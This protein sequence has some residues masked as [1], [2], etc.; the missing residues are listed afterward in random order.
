MKIDEGRNRI[1]CSQICGVQTSYSIIMKFCMP[2]LKTKIF[3]ELFSEIDYS[4]QKQR[5]VDSLCCNSLETPCRIKYSK[6]QEILPTVYPPP[7]AS[8]HLHRAGACCGSSYS[9]LI[10][11]FPGFVLLVLGGAIALCVFAIVGN[12]VN[13]FALSCPSKGEAEEKEERKKDTT[14]KERK[15]EM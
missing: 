5:Y 10:A 9:S 11:R 14:E 7:T 1:Y 15:K 13:P 2:K 4:S 8:R 3:V 12:G 6:K